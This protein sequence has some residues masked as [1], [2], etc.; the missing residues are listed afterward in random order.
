MGLMHALFIQWF[1]M[2]IYIYNLTIVLQIVANVNNCREEAVWNEQ[3]C[4]D[5]AIGWLEW[6]FLV[7]PQS[8]S[9]EWLHLAA[10]IAKGYLLCL[11]VLPEITEKPEW[12]MASLEKKTYEA[13]QPDSLR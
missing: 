7:F 8:C 6:I 2:Y 11:D 3:L 1:I 5:M 13:K 10:S 12:E 9:V 4:T